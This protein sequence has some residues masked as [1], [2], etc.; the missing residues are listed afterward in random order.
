MKLLDFGP[1]ANLW[2]SLPSGT[3]T[4]NDAVDEYIPPQLN[5]TPCKTSKW[6]RHPYALA[7]WVVS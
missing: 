6:T 5:G 2:C 3:S 1:D 4:Y 7:S